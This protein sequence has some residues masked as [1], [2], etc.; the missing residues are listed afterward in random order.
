MSNN[1]GNNNN[2]APQEKR[3]YLKLAGL[4]ERTNPNG[5]KYFVGKLGDAT[6]EVRINKFANAETHPTHFLYAVETPPKQQSNQNNN[7]QKNNNYN[8]GQNSNYGKNN[9]QQPNANYNQQQPNSGYPRQDAP[10]NANYQQNQGSTGYAPQQQKNNY[11][12]N[13]PTSGYPTSGTAQQNAN[14]SAP[15]QQPNTGNVGDYQVIHTEEKEENQT[16]SFNI[17]L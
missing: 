6:I 13:Q 14:Y 17:S 11:Q 3:T 16:P 2:N 4:Y 10:M 8:N 9:Y 15:V 1:Y 5:E 12:Q 7:Y